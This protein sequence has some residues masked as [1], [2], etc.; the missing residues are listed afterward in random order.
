MEMSSPPHVH[1]PTT[2]LPP[3]HPPIPPPTLLPT[4]QGIEELAKYHFK[5]GGCQSHLLH[6]TPCLLEPIDRRM[7]SSRIRRSSLSARLSNPQS[8]SS[9][10]FHYRSL[11]DDDQVVS[12]MADLDVA[13]ADVVDPEA[14]DQRGNHIHLLVKEVSISI[15]KTLIHSF[16]RRASLHR[17]IL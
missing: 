9:F 10:H 8:V 15:T 5:V 13:E 12:F 2:S 4:R 16:H 6:V 11:P 14:A 3:T 7:S 17:P 1:H